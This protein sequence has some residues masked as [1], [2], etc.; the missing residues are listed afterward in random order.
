MNVT[1]AISTLLA[2]HEVD[3]IDD[4]QEFATETYS[5][6]A[7]INVFGIKIDDLI[8]FWT[9]EK[10]TEPELYKSIEEYVS[11][12]DEW[13]NWFDAFDL[14]KPVPEEAEEND[15]DVRIYVKYCYSQNTFRKPHDGFLV[16]EDGM[17]IFFDTYEDAQNWIDKEENQVYY[18]G[19]GE[20]GRPQYFIVN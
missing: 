7:T 11:Q 8:L 16:D 1:Q 6:D 12:W 17:Q 2:K 10:G 19:H 13:E 20:Q 14:D 18:L 15:V 5:D 3:S 9:D 4:L